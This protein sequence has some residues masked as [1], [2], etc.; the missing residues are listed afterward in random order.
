MSKENYLD[1]CNWKDIVITVPEYTVKMSMN[2]DCVDYESE[3][4][5]SIIK[6]RA[7]FNMTDIKEAEEVLE[8]YINGELPK[9]T[10]TEEGKELLNKLG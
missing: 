7:D 4:D 9:Y 1:K 5:E 8:K 6:L 3:S 10:L 2:L